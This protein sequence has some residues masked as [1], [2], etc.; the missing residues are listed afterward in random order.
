MALAVGSSLCRYNANG[1][2]D[3]SSILHY[4]SFGALL[5]FLLEMLIDFVVAFDPLLSFVS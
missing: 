3:G 5:P 2:N 4:Y 1:G